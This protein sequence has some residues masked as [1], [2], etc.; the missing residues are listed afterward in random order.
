ML[1]RYRIVRG[2]RSP[3]DPLPDGVR[4]DVRKHVKHALSPRGEMVDA[5]LEDPGDATRLKVFA[6]AYR[7]LLEERFATDRAPFDQLATMARDE[8]VYIGC[9]CPTSKQPDVMRC[10]T[11]LALRFMRERYRTLDVRV[12]QA[13]GGFG[14]SRVAR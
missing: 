12:P 13:L 10:H 2:K 4:I 6:K 7:A 5:L 9:S 8:D 3:D 11:V 1:A 14:W